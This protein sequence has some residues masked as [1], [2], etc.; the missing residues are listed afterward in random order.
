VW[1]DF[2]TVKTS[3]LPISGSLVNSELHNVW[4]TAYVKMGVDEKRRQMRPLTLTSFSTISTHDSSG[5]TSKTA[6]SSAWGIRQA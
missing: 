3:P 2:R 1:T 5:S 4:N 6:M